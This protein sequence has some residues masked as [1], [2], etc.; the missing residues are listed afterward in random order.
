[1]NF[2]KKPEKTVSCEVCKHVILLKNAQVIEYK[3]F[4]SASDEYYCPEH[5][6]PYDYK[7]TNIRFYLSDYFTEDTPNV[8]YYIVP[9]SEMEVDEKGKLLHW[10]KLK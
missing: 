1:M 5:K 3:N 2:F 8:R 10:K 9:P 7:R 6:R 4:G